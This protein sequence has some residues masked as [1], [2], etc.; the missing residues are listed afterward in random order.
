VAESI[1]SPS[2]YRV[3]HLK[4]RLRSQGE[5]HRH[6]YRGER[7]H[8]LQDHASARYFRFSPVAYELIG[9]MDG[10]RTVHDLW[11]EGNRRF[12]DDAPSQGEMI[13]L[14]GQLHAADVL[15]C[16]VPPDTV[17]LLQRSER[18][19]K[20]KWLA[21][22]R[23]PL[24]LKFSL[25][26]PE[27]FLRRTLTYVRPL[28]SR[29]SFGLW[30]ALVIWGAVTAGLHWNELTNNVVDRIFS[31]QNFFV[32][33]LVYPLVKGLHEM[34][35][36]Y[37]IKKCG[38][39][40]HEMGVMLLVLMPIP[41]VEASAASALRSK[42]QRVLTGG[43]GIMIELF[44]AALAMQAW[45]IL[46]PGLMRSVAFNM[47][48]IGSVSTVL[49][50]ANPLLRYD[51]YYMLMDY[52][53][54]P[55]L[56]QRS[57]QYLAYLARRYLLGMARTEPPYVAPGERGWLFSY[58]IAAF[59]YRL[60]VYVAII[61]FVAEKFFVIGVVLAVWAMFNMIVWPLLKKL[62][63]LLFS[64]TLRE[65]RGR[66]VG[67]AIGGV[68]LGLMLLFLLP[69][70]RWTNAEGVVW[71][72]EDSLVRAGANGFVDQVVGIAGQPVKR[73]DIL[74]LCSNQELV[75]RRDAYAARLAELQ[76][77]YAIALI[78]D[79]V[80]VNILLE[81]INHTEASLVRFREMVDLLTIRSPKDG[82]FVLPGAV[83]M[84]GRYVKRGGLVGYVL[85][86]E[87][88]LVRT[89]VSQETVDAV[90]QRTD[91]VTI[92][93]A[94]HL[95]EVATGAIQRE[96]PGGSE[97]LPSTIFG[98]GGG[99]KIAVN[100]QDSTGTRAFEKKF[101]FDVAV[102]KDLT[103]TFIG[104]RAYVRF[105]HIPEPLGWQ[106]VRKVRQIFLKRFNV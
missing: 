55:N 27:V 99:G 49:F 34:G 37:A 70:P 8:V 31:A 78:K 13:R 17:E 85:A 96:V 90:R 106:L 29:W 44:I 71:V 36:A 64:P 5:I 89:V 2:W 83:D 63:F 60:F 72:G 82:V 84:P 88:A 57:T 56:A 18:I 45:V 15:L 30:L 48:L 104:E 80:L 94:D 24:F 87:P 33:W 38:G 3:A 73:G 103:A 93:F 52:L 6:F 54:I 100:P 32:L 66:A 21:K 11:E 14:L 68:T 9:L 41:Y 23:S 10:Q 76:N 51:G 102:K 61:M 25:W 53:E 26:D 95:T 65:L 58:S 39:E 40:C 74:L 1:F 81:E 7:W 79:H 75:T 19:E 43:A 28:F 67:V 86:D 91:R 97:K 20:N 59:I 35:H 98:F 22:L 4:L 77:R 92:L 42:W 47:V 62:H 46:E 50:N 12:G 69:F 16:N 105:E 101:Q